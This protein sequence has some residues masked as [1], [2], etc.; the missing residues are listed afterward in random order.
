M[1]PLRTS[2]VLATVALTAAC[3]AYP[4]TAGRAVVA[5]GQVQ[6]R[7]DARGLALTFGGPS[8]RLAGLRDEGVTALAVRVEGPGLV[9]P[10]TAAVAVDAVAL[11]GPHAHFP[12]LPPGPVTVTVE[13]L[14]AACAVRHRGVARATIAPDQ[15]AV[16]DVWL[17]ALAVPEPAAGG[18]A[19][20]A[21]SP[22]PSP[23]P[24]ATPTPTPTATPTPPPLGTVLETIAAGTTRGAIAVDELG[25]LW[26]YDAADR[27]I[28]RYEGGVVTA[29]VFALAEPSALAAGKF[30]TVWATMTDADQVALFT[31]SGYLIGNIPVDKAPCDVAVDPQGQAWVVHENKKNAYVLDP[32][33]GAVTGVYRVQKEPLAIAVGPTGLVWVASAARDLVQR[34]DLAGALLGETGV[35]DEPADVAVGPGGHAFVAARGQDQLWEVAT[36]GSV[37]GIRGVGDAPV[38]VL[39]DPQGR[40]WVANS[41]DGTVSVVSPTGTTTIPVGGRPA[42][43][44]LAPSG[45]V[46]VSDALTGEVKLLAR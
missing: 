33:T 31:A 1:N 23:S 36:D 35:G 16:A 2:L 20:P 12:S 37:H 45:D 17:E 44:A 21:P 27:L 15:L 46:W 41:G 5:A 26:A 43:L 32:S 25:G 10:A 40:L 30:Q 24:S 9:K 11:P 13:A 6:L 14:D 42:G 18:C 28:K 29:T 22:T 39:A 4:Q 19:S 34:L 38:A 8:F 7:P 3:S